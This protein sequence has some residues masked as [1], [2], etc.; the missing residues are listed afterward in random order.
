MARVDGKVVIVTGGALGLGNA[1]VKMLAREGAGVVITDIRED[2]GREL[3]REVGGTGGKALFLRHDVASESDW[4]Q[5]IDRTLAEYGRLDALV[6]NAGVAHNATVEETTLEKWRWLM[7]IN[8]DGVFL[9]T[10]AAIRAMK[11][12]GG[13]SIINLSSIEGIIGDPT[14][15]AYNASKGGVRL[16]TKSAALHCA[17]AGYGIRVN[18]IHPG[19]IWTPM[20]EQHLRSSGATDL[21]AARR[22]VGELHPLGHMGEPDDIAWAAVYLASDESKFVTGSE[23]V[24]DG[25]YTAR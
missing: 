13:G 7:S 14:L 8:L 23:L 18:S 10:R 25:G 4:Q 20:V 3:A 15:A 22:E 21:D 9:G 1:M 5:V 24:V 12:R 11:G 6:N 2:E 16:L 17:K 19:Y